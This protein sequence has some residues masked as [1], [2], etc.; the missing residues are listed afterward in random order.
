M[1][2]REGDE[3]RLCRASACQPPPP[4]PVL[5]IH[6]PPCS[7][8]F[9]LRHGRGF[10]VDGWRA[11]LNSLTWPEVARQL[12]V[13]AGLGRRRPKPKKEER[14]KMGQ[15]G[16]DTVQDG[17]GEEHLPCTASRGA[18]WPQPRA[19]P[20]ACLPACLLTRRCQASTLPPAPCRRPQAAPAAAPGRGHG[21]GGRLAGAGGGGAGGDAGGGHCPRDPEARLQRLEVQQDPRGLRWVAWAGGCYWAVLGCA[22]RSA[23]RLRGG[24]WSALRLAERLRGGGWSALRR[25]GFAPRAGWPACSGLA[26][27]RPTSALG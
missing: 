9:V 13:T 7:S 15:E 17:S 10:D 18:C 22:L 14:P 4:Q 3:L 19:C 21:Q 5:L 20:P 27:L 24:G 1:W 2:G 26:A 6:P 8:P 12:A 25:R 23:E 16:E 11:H